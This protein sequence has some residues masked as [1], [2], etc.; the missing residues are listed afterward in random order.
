[1][2]KTL[3]LSSLQFSTCLKTPVPQITCA[4]SFAASSPSAEATAQLIGMIV[5]YRGVQHLPIS[6]L[7][8]TV[9]CMFEKL[10]REML[11]SAPNLQGTYGWVLSICSPALETCD[12][13]AIAAILC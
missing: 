11:T 4:H 10:G 9:F 13:S 3:G 2:Y 6:L 5:M 12:L 7:Q 8:V 1:M